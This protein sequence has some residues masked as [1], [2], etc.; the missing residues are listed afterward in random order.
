[1]LYSNLI[2]AKYTFHAT[3]QKFNEVTC[4]VNKME[5][6]VTVRS[7]FSILQA[8]NKAAVNTVTEFK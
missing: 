1:M 4:L 7:L 2:G 3:K 8:P 5:S 6:N